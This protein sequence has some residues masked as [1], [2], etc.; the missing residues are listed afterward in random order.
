MVRVRV[1]FTFRVRVR[2]IYLPFPHGQ[3]GPVV[4]IQSSGVKQRQTQKGKD[5]SNGQDND[6]QHKGEDKG[7]DTKIMTN[8][9]HVKMP[10][11]LVFQFATF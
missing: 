2:V 11:E 9:F 1:R 6:A 8:P 5:K 10:Y 3:H 7:E 4:S